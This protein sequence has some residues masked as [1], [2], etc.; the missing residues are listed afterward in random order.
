[1]T[2]SSNLHELIR[3]LTPAEKRYFKVYAGS[4]GQKDEDKYLGLFDVINEQQVY[5]EQKVM[6]EVRDDSLRK[7]LSVYKNYLYRMILRSLVDYHAQNDREISLLL[8]LCQV[9][10]LIKKELFDHGLTFLK[11]HFKK[12]KNYA[13]PFLLFI[14]WEMQRRVLNGYNSS[15]NHEMADT[16]QNMKEIHQRLGHQLRYNEL[17]EH[18]NSNHYL[19]NHQLTG[20]QVNEL[21]NAVNEIEDL[22]EKLPHHELNDYH[23]YYV[24]SGYY[25]VT[26][27]WEKSLTYTQQLVDVIDNKKALTQ[28]E[29]RLYITAVTMFL[30]DMIRVGRFQE[31]ADNLHKLQQ[32]KTT[33]PAQ[34]AKLSLRYAVLAIQLHAELGQYK[35]ADKAISDFMDQLPKY[36]PYINK[37]NQAAFY[38][39]AAR[40]YSHFMYDYQKTLDI[41]NDYFA[42]EKYVT[43]PDLPAHFR[44][45]EL[46][47]H[48]ELNNISILESRIRSFRYF[49]SK[50]KGQFK[51]EDRI[52]HYFNR[53]IETNSTNKQQQLFRDLLDELN[54]MPGPYNELNYTNLYSWISEQKLQQSES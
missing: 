16:L 35:K 25:F 12:L 48:Y 26:H 38:S 27:Q 10:I 22:Q 37:T 21:S 41:I 44:V 47:V 19:R 53:L 50:N 42:I 1:M 11:K 20:S 23:Y 7:N 46:I 43:R 4:K 2:A 39:N 17:I 30:E 51:L 31:A 40:F 15:K 34:K 28:E 33:T 29:P 36:A 13:F 5:D 8:S 32:V 3:S 45:L 49:I 6:E 54:N 18:A 14:S 24:K 9:K 52:V